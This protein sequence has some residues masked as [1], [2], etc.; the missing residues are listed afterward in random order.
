MLKSTNP[1]TVADYVT[2]QNSGKFK[3][4]FYALGSSIIGFR[5][6]RPI[7][8]V[9]GTHLKGKYRVVLFVAVTRDGNNQIFPHAFGIGDIECHESWEWFMW[10]LKAAFGCPNNLLIVS[11]GHQSIA[12]A[13][14]E[15]FPNSQHGL[16]CYHIQKNLARYGQHAEYIFNLAA[17]TY[18]IEEYNKA[19]ASL[20]ETFPAVAKHLTDVVGVEKWALVKC[21]VR[22]FENMTSNAVE[23]MNNRLLWA[24]K[25]PICSVLEVTRTV[26]EEW[27]S[28]RQQNANACS[29]PIKTD[30]HKK[31]MDVI[32]AGSNMDVQ[33]LRDGV[34]K[35]ISNRKSCIVN[36]NERKCTCMK[37]QFDMITCKHALAAIRFLNHDQISYIDDY[38]KT[39][40]LK[41]LWGK[42]VILVP[43]PSE[44]C[45]PR[46]VRTQVCEP[47]DN[48]RQAGRPKEKRHQSRVEASTRTR[49]T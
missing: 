5:H 3:Y 22:R 31:L 41:Q 20:E 2:E 24:R 37:Y 19:M 15:V 34:F 48:P 28:E 7:I 38:Y 30:A 47:P 33:F 49:K 26:I 17:Y 4:A 29:Q 46:N 13:V 1:G 43:H 8:I 11:D 44:W 10:K 21:K 42:S 14:A 6:A 18:R 32:Q 16:C 23:S 9:D 45:L 40:T 27:T 36:L 39:S 25:L 35:V 12:Y